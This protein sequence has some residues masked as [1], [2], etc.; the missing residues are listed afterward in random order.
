MTKLIVEMEMPH[1]CF[2]C[3][4]HNGQG[5]YYFQADKHHRYI[6]NDIPPWCPIKGV[7]PETHGDLIDRDVLYMAVKSHDTSDATIARNHNRVTSLKNIS[8]MR[9]GYIAEKH[10]CLDDIIR[11]ETA[12]KAERKEKE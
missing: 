7:L 12:I 10:I 8:T 11:A 6:Y 1:S 3:P 5:G 9:K 4:C 2:D